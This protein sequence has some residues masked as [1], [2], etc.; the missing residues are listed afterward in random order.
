MYEHRTGN[1]CFYNLITGISIY[2]DVCCIYATDFNG[3]VVVQNYLS[4]T[5]RGEWSRQVK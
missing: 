1:T 3:V 5:G 2:S 4:R